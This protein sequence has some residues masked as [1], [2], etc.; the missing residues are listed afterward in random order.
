MDKVTEYRFDKATVRI[1][2]NPPKREVLEAACIRFAKAVEAAKR[3]A[4]NK[5]S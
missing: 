5:A 1:H 4:N 3:E 2:G